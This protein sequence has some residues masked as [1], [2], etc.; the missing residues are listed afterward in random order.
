METLD[1]GELTKQA[2]WDDQW[3][4]LDVGNHYASLGWIRRS[5]HYAALD[6]R[7][8]S[9]LPVDPTKTFVEIGSGPGRFLIYFHRV[10]GYQVSGCDYS[11]ASCT[12]A[13]ENLARAGVPGTIH[14]A[15]LFEFQGQYDVVY[16]GG[17]IEHFDSPGTVLEVFARL[18]RPGGYL[19]TTVPNLKGLNGL[20]R[21]LL[22]PETFETHRIITLGELRG[23]HERLGL[24]AVL[25]TGF[26][27][28]CL[29]RVPS[30]PFPRAPRLQRF[31]WAPVYRAS[32][33]ASNKLCFLLDRTGLQVDGPPISPH[34]LVVAQ[35]PE[36]A[37][38]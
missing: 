6:R 12:L 7:L 2:Y 14:Q 34:L 3:R 13:R 37:R 22:K 28:L 36:E 4:R 19:V 17:V 27:S 31:V 21:R 10:F 11:P 30:D 16:S 8:R 33:A 20:Y 15:D 38:S 23:W 5:Y 35:R 9:V 26:G 29:N 25:A 1:R 18:L 32:W 24:R